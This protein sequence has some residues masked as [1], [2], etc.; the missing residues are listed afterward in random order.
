MG[1]GDLYLSEVYLFCMYRH[2]ACYLRK[3]LKSVISERDSSL[4]RDLTGD[5]L[6]E[7]KD[8]VFPLCWTRNKNNNDEHEEIIQQ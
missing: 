6:I 1:A 5:E 3:Q 2:A 8:R 7:G 4:M